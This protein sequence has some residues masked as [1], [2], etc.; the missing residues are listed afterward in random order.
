MHTPEIQVFP[1]WARTVP[2]RADLLQVGTRTAAELRSGRP[3]CRGRPPIFG[4]TAAA[5]RLESSKAFAKAFMER[6]PV[7]TARFHTCESLAEGLRVIGSDEF[8]WPVVLKADGLAAGK[9]VVIAEDRAAAEAAVNAAMS[10][11]R[12]GS[13]GE[14]LVVEECLSGPE[15]SFFVVS[16][17]TRVVP[18]G[19][20]Q[21]HKRIFDEDRGPNTGG[22]GAFAP[23]P[24]VDAGLGRG[25]CA[26]SSSR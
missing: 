5:A 12:F 18:I 9:G 24:L 3:V 23:S 16:D 26:R 14:R 8:G 17:G 7:P 25:S 4:P 15:V 6:Q 1:A 10:E 20:A 11:R 13:A 22:M 21:D 19:T 2:G